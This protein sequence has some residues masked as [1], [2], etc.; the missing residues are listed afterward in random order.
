MNK[1]KNIIALGVF[2]LMVMAL[3]AIASARSHENG[4]MFMVLMLGAASFA[5]LLF[6]PFNIGMDALPD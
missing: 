1:I 4:S 3:P 6:S 2:S 5:G